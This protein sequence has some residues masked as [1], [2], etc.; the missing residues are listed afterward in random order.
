MV[1]SVAI[2]TLG[3][4]GDKYQRLLDSLERQTLPPRK[5][6]V[7]IAE[8]YPIPSE[9]IGKECYVYVKKGMVA[10]RALRYEEIETEYV[11]FLDDDLE[12][13]DD[14]VEKMFDALIANDLDVIAPDIYDN[15]H[16]PFI[17]EVMM[18][19]SGRMK[20]RFCQDNWGY[21]V[22]RTAGYSYRK[23]LN[24]PVY[25]SQTN[26]GAAF[27]CKKDD[28]LNINFEEESWLD[29][30][31]YA[32]GDDQAMYY[33]MYRSG[34]K[35]GTWYEHSFVHL[36]GGNHMTRQ[37]EKTLIFNDIRFKIVFW[38]RFIFLPS[39]RMTEKL[40]N[41]SCISYVLIVTL[42]LSLFKLRFEIVKLKYNAIVTS[43]K[44]IN[45]PQYKA[46]PRL[47]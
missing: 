21:K 22:M 30:V 13:E 32:L 43:I 14:T 25:L 9:T 5:I 33:K 4:A 29:D 28:F 19:L 41:L 37:K 8:G 18:F 11:L 17:N 15:A 2:R 46:L 38:H 26:A 47:F 36:D 16:R 44:Y 24:K 20:P 3:T 39:R 27:L 40:Y 1:Y 6:V 45:S 12:L 31:Q 42:I 34:L 35:V 7:Y 23:H 10:Q